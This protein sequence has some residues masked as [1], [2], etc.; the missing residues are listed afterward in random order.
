[1][2]HSAAEIEDGHT[3]WWP[4]FLVS[5]VS[6]VLYMSQDTE[7]LLQRVLELEEE[8]NKMLK[9]I[10]SH[11]KWSAFF[12]FVYWLIIIGS[13]AAAFYYVQPILK[14]LLASYQAL[15]DSAKKAGSIIPNIDTK[16][17]QNALNSFGK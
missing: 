10:R 8:N 2:P 11:A 7:E 6:F 17:I 13:T 9:K 14:Q 4:V 16:A 5:V 15:A 1:M 12:S 3:P